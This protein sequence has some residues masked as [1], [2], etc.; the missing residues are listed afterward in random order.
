MH[1]TFFRAEFTDEPP[2]HG[3]NELHWLTIAEIDGAFFHHC[4]EWAIHQAIK[5]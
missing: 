4:H 5:F 2:S 1:A 3:E